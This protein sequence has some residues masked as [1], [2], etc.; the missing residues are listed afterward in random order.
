MMLTWKLVA[1]RPAPRGDSTLWRPPVHERRMAAVEVLRLAGRQLRADD[2][3]TVETLIR[4]ARTWALVD[5]LAGQPDYARFERYAIP[6]LGEKE[7]FIRKAI[8]WV[9]REAA[10]RDPEWVA[11][12]TARAGSVRAR[13]RDQARGGQEREAR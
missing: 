10:K 4:D 2:L 13:K 11:T 8:G 12:W 6:M 5:P 7:F 9:L 1:R 3:T